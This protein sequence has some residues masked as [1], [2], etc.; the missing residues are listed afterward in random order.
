[1]NPCDQRGS[2]GDR[3]EAVRRGWQLTHWE[4]VTLIAIFSLVGAV[5]SFLSAEGRGRRHGGWPATTI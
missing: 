1:M 2:E 5:V 3:G 4:L